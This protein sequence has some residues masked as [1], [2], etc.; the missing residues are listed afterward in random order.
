MLAPGR[1]PREALEGKSAMS[2]EAAEQEETGIL[3]DD[4]D[5]IIGTALR[6]EIRA[7]NLP[8]RGVAIL[9]RNPAGEIYV[10][11]RTTTKDVFPGLYDMV[12]GGMVTAGESY[13]ETARRELTEELG[14][15]G[16]DPEFIFKHCY[17]GDRNNAWISLYKVVWPGPIL[18]QESEISRG[19]YMTEDEIVAKL[20]EW[21]FAPDHLELF[22][23]FRRRRNEGSSIQL[24]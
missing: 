11:R 21:R 23:R 3:V 22:E 19:D 14:V 9:V 12:V 1:L 5:R 17:Q 18:H 6:S 20:A 15:Q 8:H 13:E 10:H 7:R 2:E 16:V 24:P 4:E